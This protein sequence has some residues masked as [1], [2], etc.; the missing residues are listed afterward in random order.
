MAASAASGG[1]VGG[2]T[3]RVSVPSCGETTT[4]ALSSSKKSPAAAA[5]M[6]AFRTAKPSPTSRTF[7]MT[8]MRIISAAAWRVKYGNGV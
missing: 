5:S 1:I 7:L 8:H 6:S 3:L 2:S 4:S